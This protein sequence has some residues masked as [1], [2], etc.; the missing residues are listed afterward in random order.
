MRD[1]LIPT[2]KA[3]EILGVTTSRARTILGKSDLQETKTRNTLI[4]YYSRKRVMA[5]K[6]ERENKGKKKTKRK[7]STK[8]RR[9]TDVSPQQKDDVKICEQCGKAF[10]SPGDDY[11]CRWCRLG[12][13]NEDDPYNTMT[14]HKFRSTPC[15]CGRKR[16]MGHIRCQRCGEEYRRS[17][18][19]KFDPGVYGGAVL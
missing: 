4:N 19:D 1:T 16:L 7:K 17:K 9:G 14:V 11:I 2:E 18:A 10:K 3:A 15:A 12:I 8:S 5:I 13:P 6:A